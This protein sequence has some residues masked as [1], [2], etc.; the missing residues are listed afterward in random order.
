MKSNGRLNLLIYDP[1]HFH[2][3]YV[4]TSTAC[5][6]SA[7][8]GKAASKRLN[9]GLYNSLRVPFN[10]RPNTLLYRGFT[11]AYCGIQFPNLFFIWQ[12]RIYYHCRKEETR[13]SV[14]GSPT[15]AVQKCRYKSSSMATQEYCQF[16]YQRFYRNQNAYLASQVV[17]AISIVFTLSIS[18]HC[19]LTD[20]EE[21]TPR[22]CCTRCFGA[23]NLSDI[24]CRKDISSS[25]LG[26]SMFEPNCRQHNGIEPDFLNKTY[27]TQE[28]QNI[29][30]TIKN[31]K[32]LRF[33]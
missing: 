31:Y 16:Y 2:V 32:T 19:H 26:S 28:K 11:I 14:Y 1:F 22:G 33:Q 3:R 15:R 24:F 13:H 20:N 10:T 18:R 25:T 9:S 8:A 27:D 17:S 23:M 6:K 5:A 29:L 7:L 12:K 30:R 21:T 4:Q